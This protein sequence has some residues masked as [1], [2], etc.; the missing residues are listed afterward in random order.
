MENTKKQVL[1]YSTSKD[2]RKIK[3]Y[4][5][6]VKEC[7]VPKRGKYV[8]SEKYTKFKETLQIKREKPFLVESI[9][10]GYFQNVAKINEG[11]IIPCTR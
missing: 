11:V 8:P 7:T 1:V 10:S 3:V 6:E 4:E 9:S 5:S 2:K